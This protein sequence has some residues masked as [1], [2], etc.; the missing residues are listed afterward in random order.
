MEALKSRLNWNLEVLVFVERGKQENPEKN[1]RSEARI[2]QKF[3]PH[4]TA[5][6][7][8]EPGSQVGLGRAPI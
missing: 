8:I 4:E 5:S 3:N 1:P 2:N 7:G 6:T